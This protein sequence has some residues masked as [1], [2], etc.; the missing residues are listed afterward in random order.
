MKKT[1]FG[2]CILLI[3]SL[4]ACSSGGKNSPSSESASG[5]TS[6]VV[7]EKKKVIFATIVGYYTTALNEAAAEYHKLHPET[8][9]E[10]QVIND[11]TAYRTNFEAKMAVGG[12]EAPDI[13]HVNLVGDVTENVEKGYLAKLNDFV[14]EPNPYNG[15]LKVKEGVDSSYDQYTYTLNGD[16]A[17]LNFD[18][19]GTGFYYNQEI[20][21]KL[22]LSVP[23]TWEDLL[24]VSQKLKDNGYIPLAMPFQF[25]GLLRSAFADWNAHLLYPKLLILPG[26][27]RYDEVRNKRNTE[28]VNA[29]P[30]DPNFDIG[31]AFDPEKTILAWKNNEY[32][33]QGPGEQKWWGILKDL[34]KYYEPGYSTLDDQ[35]VYQLFLTQ[36][37]AMY[38]NGSWQVGTLLSD[39]KKLGEKAF[40]WGTFKFPGFATPDPNFPDQP[41]G[42]LAP[43]HMLGLSAKKDQEQM[44]RAED[45]LKY[46]FSKDVAQQIYERTLQVGE[47][48]QGPSLVKEVKL[49]DDVNAYLAGFKVAGNMQHAFDNF[50]VE[51]IAPE[52]ALERNKYIL[53]FY[54]D[55][56]DVKTFLAKKAEL[57]KKS[58]DEMIRKNNYDLDPKT[59]P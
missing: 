2:L 30:H 47:F 20:F 23:T 31:A 22:G 56:I 58:V 50:S 5:G 49:N 19:V 18:L 45:F 9:V 29:D 33:N 59:N 48:V 32:D 52:Y 21:E 46:L 8:E 1:L 54:N 38:W 10:I 39:M 42:I 41:R 24:S 53:D 27:A 34:S 35:S 37:A 17:N 7:K 36:K 3:F 57:V 13:V 14:N 4:S 40:N 16:I 15:N 6:E 26:D 55:K 11:N 44:S 25:E 43:G 51:G 28:I 12:S